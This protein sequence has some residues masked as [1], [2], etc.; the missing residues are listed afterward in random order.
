MEKMRM[1]KNDV[2]CQ[3]SVYSE[4]SNLFSTDEKFTV[5]LYQREYA[6]NDIQ[7]EQLIE[8]IFG[9]EDN[10][11]YIGSL[12]V[13]KRNSNTYEVI[14]GQQR[15]TTLFLLL[16][17]L[18]LPV[19]YNLFFDCR[20]KSNS[21]LF[22]IVNKKE[23]LLKNEDR[24]QSILTG[25]QI[26]KDKF[27][28]ENNNA[29]NEKLSKNLF[30]EK[31]KHV[32]LYR[33]EVPEETDL[34]RYFEIMNTRG[35]QLEQHDILKASFMSKISNNVNREL[36]ATIW[37][38]C[39][40]MTGYVQMHISNVDTRN[41]LFTNN[42]NNF[43]TKVFSDFTNS[44]YSETTSHKNQNVEDR[45][46][47]IIN[48]KSTDLNISDGQNDKNERVRF[49]SIISFPYF[50]QHVIRVYNQVYDLKL[51]LP[52]Q[53]DDQ[54]IVKDYK[55]LFNSKAFNELTPLNFAVCL[56]KCRFLFDKYIIK[57]EFKPEDDVGNNSLKQ[58]NKSES[59]TPYYT[60]TDSI[61]DTNILMMQSALRVSY[62]SPKVMHWITELLCWLNKNEDKLQNY[63]AET[64]NIIKTAVKINFL[65]I[66]NKNMG[67]DTP[68]IVFNYLDYLLWKENT[69]KYEDF[70][71]EFRNSV[72]HWYPQHPSDGTFETWKQE[73]LDNFGNLC[74]IQRNVNSKFSN[75]SPLS[76]KSTYEE[77]ISK[78]S[79]KLR[80]MAEKTK[81]DEAWKC[82]YDSFGKE[83]IQKLTDACS[84]IK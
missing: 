22:A 30:I 48:M 79:L 20:K 44:I 55:L 74:L 19:N 80:I 69:Q 24:E 21:T 33:I 14:D 16:N 28:N 68:H 39:S 81:D 67:I 52:E 13:H 51:D 38:A 18:N 76:K 58:L 7:I 31:L 60:K 17:Y 43:Q 71:F 29:I 4:T 36:F 6:W 27:G 61:D 32:V 37:D 25:L 56:L 78:G 59:G 46:D 84:N 54:K 11:Y 40:D 53:M 34:N 12:I 62:T 49:Q 26:I 70:S 66:D 82:C 57:R 50:L 35:E 1:C 3:I 45:L 65:N 83:M 75:I 8:D 63:E 5:P 64:E 77:M 41:H 42:W 23:S 73:D 15:L 9:N 47:A 10:N 72:E 2:L